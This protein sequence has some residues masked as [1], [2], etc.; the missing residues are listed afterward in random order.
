MN[1]TT[2]FL[3]FKLIITSTKQT[4]IIVCMAPYIIQHYIIAIIVLL[5]SGGCCPAQKTELK[6]RLHVYIPTYIKIFLYLVY[7]HVYQCV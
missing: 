1:K 3:L 2:P 4:V 7:V 5:L 6:C